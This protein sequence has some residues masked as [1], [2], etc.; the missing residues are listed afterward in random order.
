MLGSKFRKDNKYAAVATLI[1]SFGFVLIARAGN[2]P[3]TIGAIPD[4][5]VIEDQPTDACLLNLNDAETPVPYLQLTGASSDPVV[6]PPENIFFGLAG[7]NWYVTVTPRFGLKSGTA[8]ITVTVSDGLARSSTNFMLTVNPPQPGTARFYNSTPISI[9]SVGAATPYASQINVTGRNGVITNMTLTL[10]KLSHPRVGDVNMLLVPPGAT[11]SGVVVFSHVSGNYSA[12]NVTV[13]LTDSATYWLPSDF[14]LWPKPFRPA[15]YSTNDSFPGAPAGPYGPV[16]LSTFNGLS[17]NGIWSLYVYDDAG[18]A[19]G[20]MDGGWSLIIGTDAGGS[21]PPE[22]SQTP[23]QLVPVNT[24]KTIPFVSADD[25]TPVT[26]LTLSANSSNP[27]LVPLG[28]IVFGGGGTNQTVTVTPTAGQTGTTLLTLTVSDGTNSAMDT[29]AFTVCATGTVV[30]VE[31]AA[32]GGG[33]AVTD[34]QMGV[35]NVITVFAVA[36]DAAGNFVANVAAESWSLV[37]VSGGVASGDLVP[38]GDQK[39]AFFTGHLTGSG[40]ISASCAGIGALDSGTVTVLQN[41]PPVISQIADQ[42]TLV[43]TSVGPFPISIRDPATNVDSLTLTGTSSDQTLVPDENINIFNRYGLQTLFVTPAAGQTGTAWITI[44]A[45]DGAGSNSVSFLLTVNP[46][47]EGTAIFGNPSTITIPLVGPATNY[48][49]TITVAGVAGT[50]TNLTVTLHDMSHTYPGDVDMLLV[51]P[52]GQGVVLFSMVAVGVFPMS[53]VTFSLSDDA[54][55]PLPCCSDLPAGTYKP[56][57]NAA[58]HTNAPHIFPAPAPPAPFATTLGAFNGSCPNGTWSLY[59]LDTQYPDGGEITGGWSMAITTVPS[60]TRFANLP[61]T[62]LSL[63]GA[64][65]TNVVISWSAI[66]NLTYQVQYRSGLASTNW[67]PLQPTVTATNCV[68][69]AV[70]NP[71]GDSQRFYRILV[72]P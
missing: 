65:T 62:I 60:A 43:G 34:Q 25:D 46:P 9:P 51:G 10:S 58:D 20:R 27:A 37:N 63:T 11:N 31:T 14:P 8:T 17:A 70:D 18:P 30:Q 56:T 68:A 36:R 41:P 67:V 64:G 23:D 71:A 38:S 7:G 45:S 66:S 4:Q 15:D 16:S 57:D 29:F 33:V 35:G 42:T 59:V 1:L 47:G 24:P 54:Y 13:S 50:I 72:M 2:T 6:V 44:S 22:I 19:G 21:L 12:A 26:N 40:M 39:S 28:N 32:D 69:S 61:P 48:P 3:P 49:A 5:S 53:D 55:Y 52:T